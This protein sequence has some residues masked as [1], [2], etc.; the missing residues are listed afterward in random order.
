VAVTRTNID[1]ISV[2]SLEVDPNAYTARF[3]GQ[4]V[5]LSATEVEMLATLAANSTKVSSRRELA[6]A[7]GLSERTIDVVISALRQKIAPE[8]IRNVRGRGWILNRRTLQ[9]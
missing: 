4:E 7:T 5:E 9:A 2:G 1:T 6:Q 3:D 8:L